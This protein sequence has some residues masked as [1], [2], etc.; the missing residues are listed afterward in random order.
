MYLYSPR[1]REEKLARDSFLCLVSK[2]GTNTFY[3]HDATGILLKVVLNTITPPPPYIL[4]LPTM[5]I[6]C[7]YI[8]TLI[9]VV[10]TTDFHMHYIPDFF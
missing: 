5:Y 6:Y 3:R 1:N 10:K 9:M 4:T 2:A 8:M 7:L